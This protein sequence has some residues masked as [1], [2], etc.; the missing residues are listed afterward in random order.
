MP[1]EEDEDEISEDDSDL[2]APRLNTFIKYLLCNPNFL[3]NAVLSDKL[4][5]IIVYEWYSDEDADEELEEESSVFA[6]VLLERH[7]NLYDSYNISC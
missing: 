1:T 7:V 5:S 4:G 3:F 6:S 2:P